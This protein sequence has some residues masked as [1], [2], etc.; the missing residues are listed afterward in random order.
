[1]PTTEPRKV[2]TLELATTV[3]L[4][5]VGASAYL[6][7]VR[8]G[9]PASGAVGL[10][11]EDQLQYFAWIREAATHL[12]AGNRFDLAP[13]I[14]SFLHPAFA[15]SGL[16]HAT[17]GVSIPVSLLL[18]QPIAIVTLV[19]G[20]SKYVRRLLASDGHRFAALVLAL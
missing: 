20:F 13:G 12:V 19:A 18:W 11:A 15:L 8:S 4:V 2:I 3:G 14:R 1:M 9:P 16:V 17:L 6:G 7:V 10:Y 5:T